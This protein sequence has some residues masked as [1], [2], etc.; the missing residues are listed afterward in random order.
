MAIFIKDSKIKY[1]LEIL[2][3]KK[4]DKKMKKII[5]VE[6]KDSKIIFK[7]ENKSLFSKKEYDER[8]DVNQIVKIEKILESASHNELTDIV[9]YQNVTEINGIKIDTL[10]EE[11]MNNEAMKEIIEDESILYQIPAYKYV[12]NLSKLF[13]KII[14]KLDVNNIEVVEIV[15]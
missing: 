11:T 2:L 7:I 14:E 3:I 15:I 9:F 6:I 1:S 4:G 10:D 8:I 13:D 5:D 12:G